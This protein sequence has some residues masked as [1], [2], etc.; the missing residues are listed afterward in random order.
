MRKIGFDRATLINKIVEEN[1]SFLVMPAVIAR[2]MV[3]LYEGGRRAYKPAE[4]LEKAAFTAEGR[5]LTTEKHPDTQLLIRRSDIK[6]RVEDIR[7]LKNLI[8]PKTKRPMD[9]GIKADLRFYKDRVSPL[10]IEEVRSGARRDVSIGFTYD[11]DPTP[12]KWRGQKYDFIQRNIFIDHVAAAIPNG[13]C[14]TPYCGIGID[15]LGKVKNMDRKIG[16]DPWEESEEYI[17][18]GHRSPDNFDP[19]SLRTIDI[20]TGVRA[21]VGCP[22]GKYERGHCTVGVQV[23]S[24]LFDKNKFTMA[25]AKAWFKEHE[26]D[27]LDLEVDCPICDKIDELGKLEFSKRLVKA[28]GKDAVLKA[29]LDQEGEREK[30]MAKAKERCGKY[31]VSFKEGKGN[32]T[33]P[34]E[35]ENIPE[36]MFGDPC[37]FKYPM[38]A[39]YIMGAWSY[40]NKSENRAKGEYS[41]TEWTWIQNRIKKR[42]E[43]EE[44]EVAEDI[45][46][47]IRE[48]RALI[49]KLNKIL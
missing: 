12:G 3:Q 45:A 22:K 10:L 34:G 23:Q 46:T 35:Y 15:E 30:A 9:R 39:E 24:Y 7:F 17:R 4:E 2:E 31:P 38:T 20:T 43:A 26:A 36:N 5:W 19:D 40:V 11:E 48:S 13:R 25:Q 29:F 41:E 16:L 1:E 33:K 32:V 8:D 49:E 21:I 47:L 6:G 44:H 42:M 18:S 28:F 37:N 27:S 14:P